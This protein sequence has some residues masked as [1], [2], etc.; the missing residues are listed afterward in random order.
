MNESWCCSGP[1]CC[2]CMCGICMRCCGTSHQHHIRI[3][4]LIITAIAVFFGLIFLYYGKELMLP[5][6]HYGFSNT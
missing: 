2:S 6:E 3:A 4:Y 5:W 1:L